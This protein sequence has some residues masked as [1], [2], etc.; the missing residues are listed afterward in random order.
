M[1]NA[2]DSTARSAHAAPHVLDVGNCAADHAVLRG[3]L[4]DRFDAR[5]DRAGSAEEA[6]SAL[7]RRRYALVL[8]NRVVFDDG[9]D[10]MALIERMQADDRFRDT[11][12]MMIS[13][14]ADAQERAVGAGA[15]RGF[16]KSSLDDPATLERLAC[17]LGDAAPRRRA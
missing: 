14:H 12:V 9:G 15:L 1:S 2:H 6:L 3:M 7:T 10:G 13:N 8:V 4:V 16:G 11:P 17:H 5:V